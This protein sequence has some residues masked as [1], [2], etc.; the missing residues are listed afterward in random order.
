MRIIITLL[1]LLVSFSSLSQEITYTEQI[2]TK[3][4]DGFFKNLYND[5]F[6]YGTFYIAGDVSNS[7]ETQRKDYFIRTDPDDLYAIP[8]VVDQTVYH[9]NDYRIGIGFRKLARFDYEV[10]PGNFWTGNNKIEKQTALSAPTS[11]VKGF[12]YLVHYE[13][14]RQRGEEFINER[15]FLRHTGK[16]HIAKIEKRTNGNVGFEYVSGEVRA[17]LPIGRKFS[18]SAGAIYRT[19]QKAYGYNPIE[20]WLN[21]TNEDGSTANYWYTLGYEYDYTDHYTSY[22]SDGQI[23][24]DWIW[25][26]PEG[27]IVAYGDR[28]FRDRVMPDLMN[29]YNNAIFDTLDPYAE[30]APIIGMDVYHYKSKFWLHAYANWILPHHK[31]LKGD[32]DFNYL[33]RNNW[34]KGGL[35]QDSEPE[36]WSDYNTGINLGWKLSKSL[37][38]FI[39]GEYTKFW[40]QKIFNSS[41][42]LN[43]TLR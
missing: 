32:S 38:I 41:V 39:E 6:K 20:I 24:Y 30:V 10:K 16:Y 27:E 36:Q 13:K 25:R 3:K 11:A 37:G 31:Y 35:I 8:Q 15:Y 34:G 28:D 23:F 26:N 1:C 9:P 42:G 2:K 40:D 22:N 5:F 29:R 33:N 14:E 7:Y 4:K 12:E 19:H 21:E 43:L 17:R 18:I